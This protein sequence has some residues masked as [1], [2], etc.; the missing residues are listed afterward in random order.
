MRDFTASQPAVD[1]NDV[2]KILEIIRL[3]DKE[4]IKN[5]SVREI[6]QVDK[7]TG[8]SV[9]ES[10]AIEDN[11]E[12]ITLLEELVIKKECSDNVVRKKNIAQWVING[13]I[14]SRNQERIE[15]FVYSRNQERIEECIKKGASSRCGAEV[16]IVSEF[17]ELM[18][19]GMVELAIELIKKHAVLLKILGKYIDTLK[20]YFKDRLKLHSFLCAYDIDIINQYFRGRLNPLGITQNIFSDNLEIRKALND[21]KNMTFEEAY[22]YIM[23]KKAIE[24]KLPSSIGEYITKL[25]MVYQT[26]KLILKDIRTEENVIINMPREILDNIAQYFLKHPIIKGYETH[27]YPITPREFV[28]SKIADLWLNRIQNEQPEH[29]LAS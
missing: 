24:L 1:L 16:K 7:K 18:K 21:F 27:E 8:F 10:L 9:L 12:G 17:N 25:N 19:Q 15:E 22:I 23:E 14:Y 2:Q 6:T 5:L 4:Q 3:G 29:S 11:E 28:V 26:G 20:E 13:F